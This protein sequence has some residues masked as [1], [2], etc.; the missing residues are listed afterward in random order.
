MEINKDITKGYQT[1]PEN[2]DLPEGNK[3]CICFYIASKQL[4]CLPH[5]IQ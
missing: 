2:T 1:L 4:D 5:L 3:D